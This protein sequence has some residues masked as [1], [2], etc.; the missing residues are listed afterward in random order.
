MDN[1]PG[2]RLGLGQPGSVVELGREEEHAARRQ[3]A[4]TG[5]M[6][7]IDGRMSGRSER[8][9]NSSSH[10]SIVGHSSRARAGPAVEL[11]TASS[12]AMHINH[13]FETR[14]IPH[15]RRYPRS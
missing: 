1:L 2:E 12:T 15:D 4:P 5:G 9:S 13:L 10:D 14:S 6:A 8:F 7:R 11:A 3:N